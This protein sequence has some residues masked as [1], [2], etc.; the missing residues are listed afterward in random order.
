VLQPLG[1]FVVQGFGNVGAWAA[2][3]LNEHGGI[4]VAISD[5]TGCVHDDSPGGIDVAQL[6]RHVHRGE[7]LP[8]YPHGQHLLRDEIFDIQCDV[9]VPAALGGVIDGLLYTF[10]MYTSFLLL[11]GHHGWLTWPCSCSRVDRHCSSMLAV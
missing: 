1:V 11:V 8:K 3:L 6:L 5:A 7:P 4:I 2:R 10:P 9:F